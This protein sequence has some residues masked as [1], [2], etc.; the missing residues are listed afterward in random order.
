MKK[1]I[2]LA[3]CLNLITLIHAQSDS[4]N[5]E[6]DKWKTEPRDLIINYDAYTTSFDSA[7]DNNGDGKTDIWGIPEWVAFE[8]RKSDGIV[9]YTT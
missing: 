7:D 1:I 4:T 8:I 9:I 3:V 5:Y 2:L 6:H